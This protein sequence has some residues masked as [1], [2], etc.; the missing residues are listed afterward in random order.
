MVYMLTGGNKVLQDCYKTWEHWLIWLNVW[1]KE[2]TIFWN[3]IRRQ[4]YVGRTPA[5]NFSFYIEHPNNNHHPYSSVIK[6]VFIFGAKHSGLDDDR[7]LKWAKAE[8]EFSTSREVKPLF[9][10][11]S[12]KI[13]L[14]LQIYLMNFK[15]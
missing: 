14:S 4:I 9:N 8:I 13:I 6:C 3:V 7:L 1:S 10:Y 12:W 15:Y 2:A 11:S 5:I